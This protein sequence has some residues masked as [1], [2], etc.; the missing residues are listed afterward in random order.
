ME[1]NKP[2]LRTT[3]KVMHCPNE[4]ALSKSIA[5]VQFFEYTW[6]VFILPYILNHLTLQTTQHIPDYAGWFHARLVD[7]H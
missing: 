7:D 1:P 6:L 5:G 2:D 4:C 3:T